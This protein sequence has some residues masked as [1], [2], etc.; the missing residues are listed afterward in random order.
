[1]PSRFRRNVVLAIFAVLLVF[2]VLNIFLLV[3]FGNLDSHVLVPFDLESL[4]FQDRL[5]HAVERSPIDPR[6]NHHRLM[7]SVV[8][9]GMLSATRNFLCSLQHAGVQPHEFLLVAFDLASYRVIKYLTSSAAFLETNLSTR[10]VNNQQIIE[11]YR[12]LHYRT[13]IALELLKLG[14]DVIT[15]DTDIV[16]LSHFAELFQGTADLEAQHDSKFDIYPN[17]T[18]P[19][20]WKL[21]LGFHLWRSSPLTIQLVDRILETMKKMPKNHDQS[22]LRKLTMDLPMRWEGELLIVNVSS[23]FSL[24]QS[25]FAVRHLDG[26]LAVNTGGMFTHGRK[27][28]REAAIARHVRK[29]VMMHFFHLGSLQEKLWTMR[30]AGLWFL[31]FFGKCPATEPKG[32]EWP[33]WDPGKNLAG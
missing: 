33:W 2:S 22:V 11:F 16:F 10:G 12:F 29:P 21:N 3:G 32:V 6:T 1:M 8:N 25:D 28:W 31:N 19:A 15:A 5:R 9:E 18:I 7:I 26:L 14:C 13:G 20:P 24:N 17:R 4:P 30:H 27:K 23:L